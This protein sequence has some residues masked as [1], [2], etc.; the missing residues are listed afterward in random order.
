MLAITTLSS[1]VREGLGWHWGDPRQAGIRLPVAPV[2]PRLCWIRGISPSRRSGNRRKYH[3]RER[4]R[5]RTV[6][7]NCSVHLDAESRNPVDVQHPH[8]NWLTGMAIAVVDI[9]LAYRR[10]RL[11]VRTGNFDRVSDFL[12]SAPGA[13]LTGTSQLISK[14]TDA[15]PGAREPIAR[16]DGSPVILTSGSRQP[17]EEGEA[18]QKRPDVFRQRIPIAVEL[19]LDAWRRSCVSYLVDRVPWSDVLHSARGRFLP[20]SGAIALLAGSQNP[21]QSDLLLIN[22]SR[23][24]APT[25][26]RPEVSPGTRTPGSGLRFT[27]AQRCP[28]LDPSECPLAARYGCSR[29]DRERNIPGGSSW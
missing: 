20:L 9:Y 13:Y 4:D 8:A 25:R 29:P 15:S 6:S 23:I 5:A 27:K 24:N 21:V 17:I 11:E 16:R 3:V 12:N 2:P 19:E 14:L 28:T 7:T 22:G 26:N 18:T 1:A 10:I